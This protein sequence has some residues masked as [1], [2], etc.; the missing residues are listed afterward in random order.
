MLFIMIDERL[1]K[2]H[3]L[4][5]NN[6]TKENKELLLENNPEIKKLLEN[7]SFDGEDVLSTLNKLSLNLNDDAAREILAS[8]LKDLYETGDLKLIDDYRG[9]FEGLH[10]DDLLFLIFESNSPL[11]RNLLTS[12]EKCSLSVDSL[13]EFLIK[14]SKEDHDA[15]AYLLI[16]FFLLKGYEVRTDYRFRDAVSQW[17]IW[18]EFNSFRE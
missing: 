17:H 6:G 2:F 15:T 3:I 14:L 13:K 5:F 16:E 8:K 18:E 9:Y 12:L 10:V 4:V 7:S 1:D 11:T